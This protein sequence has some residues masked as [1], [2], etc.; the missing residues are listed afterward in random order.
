MASHDGPAANP[1]PSL[2]K[3]VSCMTANP[4]LRNT[5]VAN[6]LPRIGIA[7]FVIVSVTTRL[8]AVASDPQPI[9]AFTPGARILFQGDSITDGNRG[10]SADPNHIL[11]HGYVFIIAARHGAAFPERRLDFLNRGV[12]GNTVLDLEKRWQQDT[13]DLKPDV[14]SILIGVNDE[15]RGVPLD[16]YEQVYDKLLAQAKAANPKIKLV[17]CEPFLKPVGKVSEGIR[18]RQEIVARLAKKYG[19][20]LVKFQPVFDEAAKRA[21]ADYWVWDSVHPTYRGHQLMADEWERVVREFWPFKVPGADLKPSPARS[22]VPRRVPPAGSTTDVRY[23][24]PAGPFRPTW[25]SLKQYRCPDWFRDAKFGIWAHWGPQS[26]AEEG[27]WYARNMYIQGSP[28]YQY[29]VAHYGHPSKFGYKDIIPL[30]RAEKWD[31]D[32]LMALYRKA[33]ARYFVSQAVH[34][35]NF[36]LWDSKFHK[37]N[38]VN[39]GPKRNV[40]GDWQKAARKLGLPFGVSEHLGYSRCWFQTSHGADKTGPFAG[41]PYD[42]ADP[43]WRDLYHPP[44]QPNDCVYSQDADWHQQWFARMKDL[45]DQHRPELLYTDGGVPF[46]AAGMSLVAHLYNVTTDAG[47]KTTAVYTCK[48]GGSGEFVQDMERGVLPEVNPYPWQTD[49]SIGDWYYNRHWKYRSMT[50]IVHML[51]DVVSKNGNLLL[52]VVQRPD[53]ARCRSRANARATDRLDQIERR[54]HLW[55]AALEGLRRGSGAGWGWFLPRGFCLHRQGHPFHDERPD[56]L[57]DLPRLAGRR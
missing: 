9:A 22:I 44:S 14:L 45:V 6:R 21:P 32:R 43:Q 30:W 28:Q 3:S 23:P 51:A 52:N 19:A 8:L 20:A 37:W 50:W 40:V 38:A 12:S 49:T 11:G 1:P 46:G 42:G 36:D 54:G 26:V 48:Q 55:H 2:T 27:D 25:E 29:H 16:R 57:C 17:L 15:G 47:G 35:D 18:R 24:I 56:A 5:V 33:G 7:L 13:L 34:C 10:R 41:V 53:G 39:M 4:S 31:P